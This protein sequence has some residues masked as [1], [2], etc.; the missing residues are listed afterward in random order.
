[1]L[2]TI[3]FHAGDCRGP[4]HAYEVTVVRMHRVQPAY[5][6]GLFNRLAGESA[7]RGQ[8]GKLPVGISDPVDLT[9]CLSQCTEP[10][11]AL[12]E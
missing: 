3:G 8:I 11:F 7:P 10:S 4:V 5:T 9:R 12:I 2:A 6:C 1:M